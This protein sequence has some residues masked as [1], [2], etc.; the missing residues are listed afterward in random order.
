MLPD[1]VAPGEQIL[2]AAVPGSYLSAHFGHATCEAGGELWMRGSGTSQ[3]AAVTAGAVALLLQDRPELTPDQVKHLLTSTA[4]SMADGGDTDRMGAGGIDVAAALAAPTPGAEAVQDHA[5]ATGTGSLEG[6]RGTVHVGAG[7]DRLTGEVT[8][9]GT[10]WEPD[11]WR[12]GNPWKVDRDDDGRFAG[13]VV[14]VAN[15]TSRF[16]GLA[17]AGHTVCIDTGCLIG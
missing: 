5:P 3:A 10:A 15:R 16:R 17:D 6:A 14:R 7:D 4:V 13:K 12:G 8:A 2:S 11:T 9:F 1:V